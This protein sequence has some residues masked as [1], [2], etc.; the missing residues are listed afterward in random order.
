MKTLIRLLVVGGV[1]ALASHAHALTCVRYGS[2]LASCDD[3]TMVWDYASNMR[4][5]D[6]PGAERGLQGYPIPP[7]GRADAPAQ[8]APGMAPSWEPQ[9]P[10]QPRPTIWCTPYGNRRVCW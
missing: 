4:H 9:Q 8:V 1:I 3:G 5:V 2:A 7:G 6:G 10:Q